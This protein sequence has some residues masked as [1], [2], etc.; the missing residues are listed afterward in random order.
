MKK[1][2]AL[3]VFFYSVGIA[4]LIVCV[5]HGYSWFW[6]VCVILGYELLTVLVYLVIAR[7]AK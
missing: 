4:S 6:P 7:C 5:R 1:I 3:D 2:L